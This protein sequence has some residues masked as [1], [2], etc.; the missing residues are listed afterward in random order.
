MGGFAQFHTP[1]AGGGDFERLPKDGS[2]ASV[3]SV[4]GVWK[5]EIS[6]RNLGKIILIGVQKCS[7][8]FEIC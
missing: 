2:G 4:D 7:Q 5:M 1:Y 8:T 6:F 3:L